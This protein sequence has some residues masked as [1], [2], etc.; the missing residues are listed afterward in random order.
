MIVEGGFLYMIV[1]SSI[2]ILIVGILAWMIPVVLYV[3]RLSK[4]SINTIGILISLS[5]TITALLFNIENT[6][7]LVYTNSWYALLD[8][9]SFLLLATTILAVG[10]IIL[11]GLL[12]ISLLKTRKI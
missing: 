5:L 12:L 11:N 8:T 9:H 6:D 2:V 10:S 4:F 3:L 1:I 7:Y